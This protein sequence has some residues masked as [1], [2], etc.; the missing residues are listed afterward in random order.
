MLSVL[1]FGAMAD[2]RTDDSNAI[3]KAIDAAQSQNLPLLLPAGTYLLKSTVFVRADVKPKGTA[4]EPSGASWRGASRRSARIAARQRLTRSGTTQQAYS[5]LRMVG[6]GLEESVLVAGAPM[7]AVISLP[8]IS[9]FIEFSHFGIDGNKSAQIGI[10]AP[11]T[12]IRSRFTAVGVNHSGTAGIRAAGWINRFEDLNLRA[13][14]IG[15]WLSAAPAADQIWNNQVDV[16]GSNFEWNRVGIAI[17]AG[18][19]ILVQGN[20]LEGHDGPALVA[21]GV[22]GLSYSSNYHE[23]NN[24]DLSRQ[25]Y[26]FGDGRAAPVVGGMCALS[27]SI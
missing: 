1:D 23:A 27:L 25:V 26:G 6:D 24:L 5:P 4:A 14:G 19:S 15:L 18:D 11:N 10:D 21:A 16:I 2:G 22:W 13:N 20:D 3:Q 8:N 9:Q 17:D 12:L 7:E